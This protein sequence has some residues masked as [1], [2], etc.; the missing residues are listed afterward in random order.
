MRETDREFAFLTRKWNARESLDG[1]DIWRRLSLID[2][3]RGRSRKERLV[4]LYKKSGAL[5]GE[6]ILLIETALYLLNLGNWKW[7]SG[8]L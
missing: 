3:R 1:E 4:I 6:N 8:D 7:K 5:V 2:T